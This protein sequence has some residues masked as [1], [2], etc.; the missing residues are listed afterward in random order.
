[1]YKI[2]N[3]T[4]DTCSEWS[5]RIDSILKA[6]FY[7]WEWM[8]LHGGFSMLREAIPTLALTFSMPKPALTC[9]VW[10][11]NLSLSFYESIWANSKLPKT[12]L[13]EVLVKPFTFII[14]YQLFFWILK[15]E[16]AL[17]QH[18]SFR[19]NFSAYRNPC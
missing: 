13:G 16:C 6:K 11:T 1:M 19:Q 9:C 3:L 15:H 7:C 14:K 4:R 18:G 10:I 5:A 8:L 2:P 17:K 12:L